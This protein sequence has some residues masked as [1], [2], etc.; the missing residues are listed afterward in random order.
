M[1]KTQ[2]YKIEYPDLS[3]AAD[4]SKVG[5]AFEQT[6]KAISAAVTAEKEAREKKDK[7]IIDTQNNISYSLKNTQKLL[8]P[9]GDE[10]GILYFYNPNATY[11]DVMINPEIDLQPDDNIMN[12]KILFNNAILFTPFGDIKITGN[13]SFKFSVKGYMAKYGQQFCIYFKINTDNFN[14]YTLAIYPQGITPNDTSDYVYMLVTY[15]ECD[16][17]S[18]Q[19][20]SNY[21]QPIVFTQM[22]KAINTYEVN[23]TNLAFRADMLALLAV[24]GYK[25][26]P[27]NIRA[28]TTPYYYADSEADKTKRPRLEGIIYSPCLE[29][30]GSYGI[31]DV[32]GIKSIIMP[33]VETI[34]SRGFWG[35]VNLE[36]VFIPNCCKS[37]G[38][39]AFNYCSKLKYII[40][41]KA[42]GELSN[43]P[44]YTSDCAA[45]VIY[46]RRKYE[47]N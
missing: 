44:F 33:R 13:H 32:S 25:I 1:S 15:F 22:N 20:S 35:N 43:A 2:H 42:K 8:N 11:N 39:E 31:D 41:D 27:L 16:T 45:E 40:V 7:E 21:E 37:I 6:D 3:A 12:G 29:I 10:C 24:M 23:K 34:Q 30:V 38:A 5:E 26:T 28:A 9:N 18:G 19:T 46:L 17:N 36:T 14:D 47:T 4:I